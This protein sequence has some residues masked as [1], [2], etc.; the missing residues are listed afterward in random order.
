M[1]MLLDMIINEETE[2]AETLLHEVLVEHARGIYREIVESEECEEDENLDESEEE[3]DESEDE[4]LEENFGGDETEDFVSDVA[5]DE[6]GIEA[7][8]FGGDADQD[9]VDGDFDGEASE[10]ERIDD[11]EAG[12]AEL[13][14]E[15]E[16]LMAQELE[17]P[18][19]DEEDFSFGGEEGEEE[20]GEFETDESVFEATNF[21]DAADSNPLPGEKNVDAKAPY[22]NAP[23]KDASHGK[24]V[25]IGKGDGQ[26]KEADKSVKKENTE[27]NVDVQYKDQSVDMKGEGKYAGTGKNSK[28]GSVNAKAP[29]TKKPK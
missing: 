12:L 2:S 7:D 16:E 18:H 28:S 17:E 1:S 22:T 3:V 13:Q 21:L 10:G 15:F 26:G 19:H 14:A 24:P 23:S 5:Q 11:L 20:V 8:E 25:K 4:T 27:D 29:L 9:A 6:E